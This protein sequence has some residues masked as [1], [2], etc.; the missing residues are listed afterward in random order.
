MEVQTEKRKINKYIKT[1]LADNETSVDDG[2]VR[3]YNN[4]EHNVGERR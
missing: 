4:D 2:K 3:V 1:L